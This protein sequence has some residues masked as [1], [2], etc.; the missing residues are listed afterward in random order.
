MEFIEKIL[1]TAVGVFVAYFIIRQWS[2]KSGKKFDT[3]FFKYFAILLILAFGSE[4][5]VSWIS[6]EPKI[7]T[8][9]IE[10][11]K[12]N[13]K[14]KREI[15]SFIGYG[16]NKNEIIGIKEFPTSIDFTLFGSEAEIHLSVL[17]DSSANIFEVKEYK[18]D[19]LIKE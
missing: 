9:T 15:G 11:L 7:V 12:V 17:V 1:Y 14:I 5:L 3:T 19:T 10:Q 2:G 13:P 18:V 4:L 6:S 16:Y 8:Q